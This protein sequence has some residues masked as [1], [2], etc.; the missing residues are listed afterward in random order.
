MKYVFIG[1]SVLILTYVF[2]GSYGTQQKN[3]VT[4]G[5][6]SYKV[7]HA[8]TDELRTKGLSGRTSL[9]SGTVMLFSFPTPGVYGFW[10]KDML[11]PID[12]LWTNEAGNAVQHIERNL[13]PD[14]YPKAFYP[15]GPSKYVLEIA[16]DG[17]KDIQIG[18]RV[19]FAI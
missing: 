2:W 1:A 10:M 17:F 12:I 13:S 7:I 16:A 6:V 14:T 15:P 19:D 8:D 9:E 3:E 18:D 4:V 11:F 5:N